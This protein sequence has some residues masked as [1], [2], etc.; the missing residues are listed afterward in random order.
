MLGSELREDLAVELY[1][2]FLKLIDEGGIRLMAVGAYGGVQADDP[3]RA[4]VVLLIASV[5]KGVLTG[6]EQRLVG[7]ALLLRTAMAKALRA[8]EQILATLL[9]H[10]PSF[11]SC[12]T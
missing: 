10:D 7:L 3:E 5:R 9:C 6:V 12:H 2:P 8:C 1:A 11:D 4:E